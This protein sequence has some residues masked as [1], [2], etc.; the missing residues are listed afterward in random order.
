MK[1]CLKVALVLM[2]AIALVVCSILGTLAYLRSNDSVTNTFTVGK[3]GITLDEAPVNEYGE[4]VAGDRVDG[5]TYK[6]IPGHTY[7]KDPTVT[8]TDGS[9]ESYIR[10]IVKITDYADVKTVF[11]NDFLPQNFV[12]GWDPAVWVTTNVIGTENNGDTAVYEFRYFETVDTLNNQPLEL[13]ALFDSFEIPD[14]IS[15]DNLAKLAEMKIIVEAHAI[16]ADGF[17]GNE[18]DAWTAFDQEMANN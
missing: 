12:Q 3:V 6:L 15:N 5:N 18:D 14:G 11:G 4:V 16:Q 9:E 1:K 10:M 7:V 13:D 8:V 2:A 17:N